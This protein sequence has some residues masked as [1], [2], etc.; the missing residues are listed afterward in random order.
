MGL[1][2]PSP[3]APT[4]AGSSSTT[5]RASASA[6]AS[7][8][9]DAARGARR[10]G[11]RARL[12]A[13]R[14]ALR[15][16]VHR[17]HRTRV[18]DARQRAV[19][20]AAA[21]V[22]I[23]RRMERLVLDE[24]S[25]E[26]I[27]RGLANSI[28]ATVMVLDA[29]GRPLASHAFRREL[30]GELVR[31]IGAEVGGA[32]ARRRAAGVRAADLASSPVARSR[33]RCRAVARGRR[34]LARRGSGERQRPDYERF[35]A[36]HAVM[37]VALAQMR[38]RVVAETER[39][40]AGD[41]LGV[42]LSG[43]LDADEGCVA[44]L[45]PFDIRGD[46]AVLVFAVDEPDVLEPRARADPQRAGRPGARRRGPDGAAPAAVR[47]AVRRP[48]TR[49]ALAARGARAARGPAGG[50]CGRRSAARPRCRSCGAASTRR[51]ARSRCGRSSTGRAGR[52]LARRSWRLPAAALAA[53]RRRPAA[54]LRGRAAADRAARA[55]AAARSSCA[56]SRRSSSTT[57]TG[58]RRRARSSA[59]GTRCAT[60]CRGSRS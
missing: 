12:P 26:E 48:P 10:R 13:L 9:R 57:A 39:R 47:G 25:L 42:V 11:A 33:C 52:R 44:R 7:R 31:A 24:R 49:R 5:S 56:R 20:R 6:S 28:G 3:S 34:V 14:G 8:H 18:R 55:A 43:R 22:A 45:A 38:E 53:G 2:D 41:V 1:L 16:A 17:D 15:D 59:T 35:L 4:S 54:V 36:H 29:T 23:Q 30:D 32:L 60:A 50:S 40:L 46:A 19:R 27:V 58:R 51:A 21:R 37:V